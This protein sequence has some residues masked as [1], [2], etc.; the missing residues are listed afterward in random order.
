M[1]VR[2]YYEFLRPGEGYYRANDSLL[3]VIREYAG[4]RGFL[5]ANYRYPVFYN[6]FQTSN[7]NIV[8][9]L[10][11][12]GG[13]TN[14]IPVRY[15]EYMSALAGGTE[16]F[17]AVAVS[18]KSFDALG[19]AYR[20]RGDQ[21]KCEG[22][23]EFDFTETS[24]ARNARARLVS[25]AVVGGSK[26]QV[27]RALS[28]LSSADAPVVLQADEY[29]ALLRRR[30]ELAALTDAGQRAAD[31]NRGAV[32][33]VEEKPNSFTLDVRAEKPCLL[34]VSSGFYEGMEARVDGQVEPIL[35]ADHALL[36]VPVLPGRH[37]VEFRYRNPFL[38]WSF[39]GAGAGAVACAVL[40]LWGRRFR[41]DGPDGRGSF[42]SPA[43]AKGDDQ[44]RAD[45]DAPGRA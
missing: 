20:P 9:G 32:A 21:V 45:Q 43:G 38:G 37:V 22:L 28:K 14:T 18:E 33:W 17:R 6:P 3:G 30:P 34:R 35:R 15:A 36:A 19:V 4:S 16:R 5:I 1:T 12:V 7:S 24:P 40:L 11:Q 26:A 41:A 39:A 8:F 13:F 44:T 42:A 10:P 23:R 27:L 25:A 29:E 31:P 2:T